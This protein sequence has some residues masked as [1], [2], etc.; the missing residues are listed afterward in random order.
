MPPIGRLGAKAG[1]A[2]AAARRARAL[3]AAALDLSAAEIFAHPERRLNSAQQAAP[4]GDAGADAGARAAEPDRRTA[5]VLGSRI[6]TVRRHARPAPGKR[7]D[8]RGRAGPLA[9]A[10]PALPF[11]RSRHRHRLSVAGAPVRVPGGERYRDRHRAGRRRDGARQCRAARH[12]RAG[13][14]CRRKLGCGADRPVRRGDRQSPLHRASRDCRRCRPR[15]AIR[16]DPGARRR[17]RRAGRVSRDRR[18][19][20]AAATAGRPLRRRDRPRAGTAVGGNSRAARSARR[21]GRVPI[22]P[23]SSALSSPA[24]NV[25]RRTGAAN[26]RYADAVRHRRSPCARADA[27][28]HSGL[29]QHGNGGG[30]RC[31][32]DLSDWG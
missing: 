22:S 10:R 3:L 16:S 5:R 6:P 7:D 29:D 11:S 27:R 18:R 30:S 14:F 31:A 4:L 25:R 21:G 28:P 8:R 12:R 13:A 24:G 23:A 19:T 9:G 32:S 17:R 20:A 15:C 1:I 26:S 2:G